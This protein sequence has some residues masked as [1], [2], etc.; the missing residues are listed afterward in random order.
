MRSNVTSTVPL[1]AMLLLVRLGVLAADAQELEP[2]L[3]QSAPIDVNVAAVSY[4]FSTG[5]VLF[6]ASLPIEGASARVH[7]L[8]LS[9]V[10]TLPVF[11]RSAKFDAQIP[12]S[13]S[14]FEGTVAG[15]LRTRSPSGLADPRFRLG[16]NFVGGRPLDPAAF[17]R[18]RQRTVVGASIQVAVP[19]GQYDGARF[20]NLGAHR[21]SF[22]PEVGLSHS[23][24]RWIVEAA[25]G[26][27]FFTDND[28]FFGGSSL[29]QRPFYFVKGNAIYVF[30]RNLWLSASYGYA[31]GGETRVNNVATNN[32]QRNTRLG[33]TL[34]L[35]T[36]RATSLKIVG[37]SGLTTRL[38]SDF[39]SMAVAYQYTWAS[40][41]V[42]Q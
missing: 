19:L 36:G 23:K 2:G 16:V 4:G 3:Y 31:T 24:G 30:K 37:T 5:N 1:T 39:D 18:S 33:L 17:A 34:S 32:V 8:G 35:P 26:G 13:W 6:E 27:W 29:T 42:A 25:T 28:D 41:R 40:K 12:I 14:G 9:Y 11:G 21:W 20:I 15:E 38:G 10:R 7:V 22:R